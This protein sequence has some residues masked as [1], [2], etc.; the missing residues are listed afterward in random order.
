MCQGA[1]SE[2]AKKFSDDWLSVLG[3]QKGLTGL[4]KEMFSVIFSHRIYHF[5]RNSFNSIINYKILH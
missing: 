4:A 1:A 2:K 3:V 5:I